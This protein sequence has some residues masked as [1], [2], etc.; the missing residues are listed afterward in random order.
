MHVYSMGPSENR[1]SRI[2]WFLSIFSHKASSPFHIS[3]LRILGSAIETVFGQFKYSSG[4]KLDAS[5]YRVARA[6]Y[7]IK[8]SSE[9]H[10]S[11]IGYW[12]VSLASN[13]VIL[14]RKRY[15]TKKKKKK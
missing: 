11:G 3:P 9:A 6:A 4:G 14:E 2:C 15:N 1:C 7:F 12:D 10:H 5:N 8:Q 13:D